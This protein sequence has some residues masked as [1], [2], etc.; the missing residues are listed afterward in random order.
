MDQKT[1]AEIVARVLR[2]DRQ[3]YALLVEEYQAPIYNLVYRMTK[4]LSDA[5]E[6]TQESFLRAFQQLSRYDAERS[7]YTWLYTISLNLVRNHLKKNARRQMSFR[8]E[9]VS[10]NSIISDS[11][12]NALQEATAVDAMRQEREK[13]LERCLDKLSSDLK[14]MLVLRFY[15]GLTFED[16]AGITGLS[17]SAAKMRVYRALEKLKK[18]MQKM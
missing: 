12:E 15:Q 1:E 4:N 3:A 7:F 14:E 17:Q 9:N 18:I 6:I 10:L 8:Q 5:E 16:I 2:G 13:K 11:E